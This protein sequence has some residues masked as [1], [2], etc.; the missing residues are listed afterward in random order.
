MFWVLRFVLAYVKTTKK[1]AIRFVVVVFVVISTADTRFTVC[2]LCYKKVHAPNLVYS[3]LDNF[4]GF[5]FIYDFQ[6]CKCTAKQS[7]IRTC[8]ND[9]HASYRY[10]KILQNYSTNVD[11]VMRSK[12]QHAQL[13]I[14]SH[15]TPP[16]PLMRCR[17]RRILS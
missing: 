4:V 15:D 12:I 7:N 6:L 8:P 14:F 10:T 9:A 1:L 16:P 11:P 17:I 2:N 5:M 13:I 3:T